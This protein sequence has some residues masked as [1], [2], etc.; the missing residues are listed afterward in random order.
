MKKIALLFVLFSYFAMA[1]MP[2]I[3][4]LW[5]NNN[6]PYAG[7]FLD[8]DTPL[9]VKILS[10]RQDKNDDQKYHLSGEILSQ[11]NVQLVEGTIIIKKYKDG[12]R[13][14]RL[15]GEYDFL[16]KSD[17]KS[18]YKGKFIYTFKW[19]K[20]MRKIESNY[21]KF[22]GHLEHHQGQKKTKTAW[23]NQPKN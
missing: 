5:L 14:G 2:N 1:Q 23:E 10:S 18:I 19:N 8:T 9:Q 7:K 22:V 6:Q 3:S 11:N 21:I 15:F 4:K 17:S 13:R 12:N 20:K 16:V